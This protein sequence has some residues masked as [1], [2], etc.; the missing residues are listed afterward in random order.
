MYQTLTLCK[1]TDGAGL[2]MDMFAGV[3]GNTI[4]ER[5]VDIFQHL[6]KLI[7]LAIQYYIAINL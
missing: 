6:F 2:N 1:G 5:W 4:G 7:V 3:G